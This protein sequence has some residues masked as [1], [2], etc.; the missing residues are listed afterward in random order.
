MFM[1]LLKLGSLFRHLHSGQEIV[2]GRSIVRYQ[3]S[4]IYFPLQTLL[5][6]VNFFIS[7]CTIF[8]MVQMHLVGEQVGE[9]DSQIVGRLGMTDI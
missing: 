1:K 2:A 7:K 6:H 4:Y 3:E 5:D 8:D 9:D